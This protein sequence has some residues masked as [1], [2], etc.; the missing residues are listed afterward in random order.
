MEEWGWRK[1]GGGA[2]TLRHGARLPLLELPQQREAEA[3]PRPV[4]VRQHRPQPG[5]LL[6]NNLQIAKIARL[7]KLARSD[8]SATGETRLSGGKMES[9]QQGQV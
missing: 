4:H 6:P 2:P 1:G 9:E 8:L 7:V 3:G 5:E